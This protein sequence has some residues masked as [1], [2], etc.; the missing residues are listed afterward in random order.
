[1][2][3]M[4]GVN[5]RRMPAGRVA[6]T[7]R[8]RGVSWGS[9]A[10]VSRGSIGHGSARRSARDNLSS[11]GDMRVHLSLWRR[12]KVSLDVKASADVP[13][14]RA[15][16][17]FWQIDP[18]L[19]SFFFL[20]RG[21]SLGRRSGYSAQL[22]TVSAISFIMHS[23]IEILKCTRRCEELTWRELAFVIEALRVISRVS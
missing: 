2:C 6:E 13:H 20:P 7:G 5:H 4:G 22:E 8:N 1:M 17:H 23:E 11:N 12:V 3:F 19:L 10:R 16:C 21:G 14:Y 15:R 18:R 9:R